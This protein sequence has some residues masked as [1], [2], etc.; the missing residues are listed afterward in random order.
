MELRQNISIR[1][2]QHKVWILPK[3]LMYLLYLGYPSLI[4]IHIRDLSV[5][6][7]TKSPALAIYCWFGQIQS[8]A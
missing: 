1:F 2:R 6:L 8:K 3:P 7:L 5:C 4:T